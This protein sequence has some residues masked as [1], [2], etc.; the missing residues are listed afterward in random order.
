MRVAPKGSPRRYALGGIQMAADDYE[1]EYH[2]TEEGWVKG[3]SWFFNQL[4]GEAVPRA[5]GTLE[6]WLYHERQ[7]STYSRSDITWERTWRDPDADE[8]HIKDLHRKFPKP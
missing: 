4:Q 2:L 7:S 3:S 1:V 6:T 8:N 5:K